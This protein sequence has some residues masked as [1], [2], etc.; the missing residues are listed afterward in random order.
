MASKNDL[1]K[2]FSKA[3]LEFLSSIKGG[4]VYFKADLCY[5][6]AIE[7]NRVHISSLCNDHLFDPL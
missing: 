1:A 2:K 3:I 5:I 4:L 6:C 7:N